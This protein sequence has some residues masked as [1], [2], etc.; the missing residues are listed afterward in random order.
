LYER[1][2]AGWK[3]HAAHVILGTRQKSA[4]V[5]AANDI[6]LTAGVPLT[7]MDLSCLPELFEGSAL[8]DK[9]L[10]VGRTIE[11][12]EAEGIAPTY[13][14][15]RNTVMLALVAAYAEAHGMSAV[16]YGAH[17]SDGPHYPDTTVAYCRAMQRA[18][19][20]GSNKHIRLLSPFIS[21]RKAEIIQL[22]ARLCVPV[23]LSYTCY[24]GC[25]PS[26]G[27]CDA[28][29]ARISAFVEAGYVD[30]IEYQREIDWKE[31]RPWPGG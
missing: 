12:I 19:I 30:P 1:Q 2:A 4:Q 29:V 28:C 17:F 9:V 8:T 25:M 5:F 26:C 18:L 15:F 22:A 14:P 11:E 23:G 16:T 20:E 24:T 7:F 6:A 13:L 27:V 3:P 21:F 31:A 10:P